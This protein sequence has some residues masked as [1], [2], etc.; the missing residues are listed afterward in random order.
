MKDIVKPI[1]VLG[2]ICLVVTA[3][4][5]YINSVTAPIIAEASAQAEAKA[6]KEVLAEAE[7]FDVVYDAVIGVNTLDVSM[8]AEVATVYQAT[9][10]TG[11]V[12]LMH[13]KGYGGTISLLCGVKSDGSIESTQTL[14]HSETSGIGSRVVDNGSSYRHNYEGK[15]ADDYETVDALTGAT[16]S[17]KAYKKAIA[18]AF[19]AYKTVKGAK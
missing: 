9:N 4:L 10:G 17:S 16:I 13:T 8:P 1:A 11:Y 19:E 5:A 3:L 7:D 12:F 15:T 18:A 14:A 2:A 6:V